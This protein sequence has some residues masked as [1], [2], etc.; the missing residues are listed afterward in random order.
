MSNV[1]SWT[2]Y[3]RMLENNHIDNLNDKAKQMIY[4]IF[5]G[6][7]LSTD[8][9]YAL[10]N[11]AK[12]KEILTAT[13]NRFVKLNLYKLI[14][15][16]FSQ[17]DRQLYLRLDEIDQIFKD[18]F[19]NNN[20]KQKNYTEG[21]KDC[22][23]IARRVNKTINDELVKF[24]EEELQTFEILAR[25]YRSVAEHV[26]NEPM[27]A[28]VR[29]RDAQ[30]GEFVKD[31]ET[32]KYKMVSKDFARVADY[33]VST[34]L[35]ELQDSTLSTITLSTVRE[36]DGF[37][38][39]I[40]STEDENIKDSFSKEE[41]KILLDKSISLISKVS[42]EKYESVRNVL[43]QYLE[44]VREQYSSTNS[45]DFEEFSNLTAK[46][47][48]LKCAT[49]LSQSV[50][51]VKFSLDFIMGKNMSTICD[52]KA[53]N[54]QTKYEKLLKTYYPGLT[55]RGMDV[56]GHLYFAKQSPSHAIIINSKS[57]FNTTTNLIDILL[58]GLGEDINDL[59]I[60][61]KKVML[62]KK[63][64][65]VDAMYTKDNLLEVFSNSLIKELNEVES[66][67][68]QRIIENIKVLSQYLL[69]SDLQKVFSHNFNLLLV[70]TQ[71]IVDKLE[72]IKVKSKDNNE[73]IKLFH[74][75]I[76]DK[77]VIKETTQ[78]SSSPKSKVKKSSQEQEDKIEA[79]DKEFIIVNII[80]KEA[81]EIKEEVVKKEK[82]FQ[83]IYSRLCE[84]LSSISAIENCKTEAQMKKEQRN[85]AAMSVAD[86]LAMVRLD[87]K[88]IT[89]NVFAK[90]L[91]NL[92]EMIDDINNYDELTNDDRV[93]L[94]SL[95]DEVE[96]VLIS[97]LG[98]LISETKET[99]ELIDTITLKEKDKKSR[100]VITE[101]KAL[102]EQIKQLKSHSLLIR[103]YQQLIDAM[104]EEQ[105]NLDKQ[106]AEEMGH[107]ITRNRQLLPELLNESVV[108]KRE[109][110]YINNILKNITAWREALVIEEAE[111]ETEVVREIS[112]TDEIKEK[113]Q[114]LYEQ[115]EL[116]VKT[117][118]SKYSARI[119]NNNFAQ[120]DLEN[121]VGNNP[122]GLRLLAMVR[123]IDAQIA[124]LAEKL[125]SS[126]TV[127]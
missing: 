112:S 64:F 22:W 9:V 102:S 116:K 16:A 108:T 105:F 72:E 12:K 97:R 47:I 58:L 68:K 74:D 23:Q 50:D 86:L 117:I 65:D 42:A 124:E 13:D 66:T 43:N 106:Q 73:Y 41:V 30:T 93:Y 29:E 127:E 99:D 5:R 6:H 34:R 100:K 39:S 38:R 49:L 24:S 19:R 55:L 96:K 103:K 69:P 26:E 63:G 40:T 46:N 123:K 7:E 89:K 33:I 90:S 101:Y 36:F 83:E 48:I 1:I 32:N 82:S 44:A 104:E 92:N 113:I 57:V 77:Y 118:K 119:R 122:Y 85:F 31:E 17:Y 115:R 51:S 18:Y 95:I 120:D 79:P 111:Q 60:I 28:L 52:S 4:D 70:D 84:E 98:T 76:N 109:Y 80:G 94:L 88:I 126:P 37:L 107:E 45:K 61:Q 25:I 20:L 2:S 27:T 56:Q 62:R 53:G 81:E 110:S 35:A 91:K 10:I 67:Q 54:K 75:F 121:I 114:K 59:D 14:R 8:E 11:G 78:L 15:E 87:S 71:K 3:L 21:L 125:S